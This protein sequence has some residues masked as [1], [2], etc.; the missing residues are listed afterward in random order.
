[1]RALPLLAVLLLA[2]AAC[3]PGPPAGPTAAEIVTRAG[4]TLSAANAFHFSYSN[5]GGGAPIFSGLTLNSA[6]GDFVKPDKLKVKVNANFG[7]SVVEM[8]V[9]GVGDTAYLTN[10]LTREWIKAPG[11]LSAA[12]VFDPQTGVAALLKKMKNPT[13]LADETLDGVPVYHVRGDVDAADL[14]SYTGGRPLSGT[15]LKTDIWVGK[16]DLR[17]RQV[18][19][20][21]KIAEEDPPNIIR[22]IRLTSFDQPVTI[23]PPPGLS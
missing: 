8:D 1:M 15:L 21:G 18:R 6:E 16:Q 14:S 12:T 4:E 17:I 20:P 19:I 9:I 5:E 23:E 13:R 22:T 7:S 11:A 10:P 3:Q 2:L